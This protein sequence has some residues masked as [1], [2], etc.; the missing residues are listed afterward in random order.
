ML[1]NIGLLLAL[2][3]YVDATTCPDDITQCD[4][5][6]TCCLISS[7][8]YGCCPLPK[9]VCCKDHIHCC[10]HG[11]GCD[12]ASSAC[13]RKINDNGENI[14]MNMILKQPGK[15]VI[16]RQRSNNSFLPLVQILIF[17]P[18]TLS[19]ERVLWIQPRQSVCQSVSLS[20]DKKIP[21][22]HH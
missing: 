7:K 19:P 2:N 22:P 3:I 16:P 12:L 21:T 9:A 1:L 11:F 4:D 13:F 10:P 8:E 6:S 14:V 5:Q 20:C 18:P 15:K 17:G